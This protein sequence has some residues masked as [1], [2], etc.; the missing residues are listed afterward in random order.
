MKT[1]QGEI[2]VEIGQ[3]IRELRKR[4]S[5]KQKVLASYLG[6]SVSNL[7][8]IERGKKSITIEELCM[9]SKGLNTSVEY[10]LKDIIL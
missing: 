2:N 7:S 1:K 9:L 4:R 8:R 3:R 5:L 6:M 10:L